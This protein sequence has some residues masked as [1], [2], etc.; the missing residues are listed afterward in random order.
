MPF[1]PCKLDHVS[2]GCSFRGKNGGH[3]LAGIIPEWTER[4]EKRGL[5]PLGMQNLGV[6]LYQRLMPG[7][8]NVT[9]RMRYY[10]F[11]CW[12]S[13]SYARR[14]GSTDYEE[15]RRWVRRGEALLALAASRAGW[16]TGDGAAGVGGIEWANEALGHAVTAGEDIIDFS[17]AASVEKGVRTYLKQSMGVFGGAYYSQMAEMGLFEMGPDD[18]QRATQSGRDLAQIFRSAIGPDAE[19]AFLQAVEGGVVSLQQLD[20][21]RPMVPSAVVDSSPERRAYEDLLLGV[22]P[23]GEGAESR[24][25][26]LE[27]VLRAA[28]AANRRPDESLVRW[29][30]FDPSHGLNTPLESQRL[31]WEAYHCHDMFQVATAALL[32]WSLELLGVSP[33]GFYPS[34]FRTFAEDQ[35]GELFP[36]DGHL[37]WLELVEAVGEFDFKEAWGKLTSRRGGRAE[38]ANVAIRLMIALDAR[39]AARPDLGPVVETELRPR[40]GARSIVSELRWLRDRGDQPLIELMS[41][42]MLERIVRRHGQIALQK[43]RRQRDYTFLIEVHDGRLAPLSA[44]QPVPTTPRLAPAIQF[45]ADVHL[46]DVN[47]PTSRGRELLGAAL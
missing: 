22:A 13:D 35:L 12:L 1:W 15:W 39:T 44:Y 5:D 17:V 27:L 23:A 11:Y 8:S 46:I 28:T 43:L 19:L 4:A 2:R 6:G 40:G 18:V 32:D 16:P 33:A 20:E 47:G 29:H 25:D 3:L 10:G 42:Y 14:N 38:R 7:I 30:L 9:L 24:R 34:Q 45:L 41:E 36:S 21:L 31:R 26:T 37:Y